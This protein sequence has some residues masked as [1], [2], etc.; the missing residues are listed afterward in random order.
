V[1]LLMKVRVAAPW[2]RFSQAQV[3]AIGMGQRARRYSG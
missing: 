3:A 1:A 2:K